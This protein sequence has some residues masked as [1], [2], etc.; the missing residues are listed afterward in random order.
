MN[1]MTTAM[2]S[3]GGESIEYKLPDGETVDIG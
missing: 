3:K 1:Q 2:D